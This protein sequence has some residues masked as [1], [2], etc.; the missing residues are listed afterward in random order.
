MS[1][2]L[3]RY[4]DSEIEVLYADNQQFKDRGTLVAFDDSWLELS[5]PSGETFLIPTFAV[6]IVKL[7][8]LPGT[9][10]NTLL[11]PAAIA[12]N[13]KKV[14]ELVERLIQSESPANQ[15]PSSRKRL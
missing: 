8:K 9:D 7:I 1:H 14:S 10:H 4:L 5:K 11:R 6:R 13:E 15:K 12:E 3:E 2:V